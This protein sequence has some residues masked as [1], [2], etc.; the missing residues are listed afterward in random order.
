MLKFCTRIGFVITLLLAFGL[1]LFATGQTEDAAATE[2]GQ[3]LRVGLRQ[4]TTIDPALG[5]NDPEVMFNR[6]QY[7]YLV[8]ISA[9]GDLSPSLA[10]DWTISE[11]G[12][13]YTFN[14]RDDV[15]FEDGEQ[16]TAD[17][18]VF[19][20]NRLV[21]QG[22]SIVS[23]LGQRQTGETEDGSAIFEPTWTVEAADDFTAVFRLEEPNADF[24]FGVASRFSL[25]VQAG[26]EN[27]NTIAQG[28]DPYANFNGTGPF[29]LTEYEPDQRATFVANES[30]WMEGAPALDGLELVFF[31]N[32]QTQLDALRSGSLDFIIKVPEDL[33]DALNRVEGVTVAS[34]ATN[35]HPVIRLR[36]DE[37]SIGEDV[38]MRQAFKFAT[39]RELINQ[40]VLGGDGTVANN[41]PI[42]PTYGSLYNPQDNRG[43]DPE[44]A[45]ELIAEVFADGAGNG[46]IEEVDGQPRI[47]VPFYVGDTFEYPLVAEFVQQQWAE[48]GIDVE[49]NVVPEAVYYAEGDNNWLNTQLGMTAWGTRPTPQE[50]LSVAYTTGAPFNEARWSN[51][52]L[53]SLAEEASRTADIEERAELYDQISGIFFESGPI[54]IPYFRPV[55][56]GYVDTI[57]GLDMH[58]FPGRTDFRSVRF[59]N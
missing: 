27:V 11:D 1:P 36:T 4:L 6:V 54:L 49:L 56:G 3:V 22:S 52:E 58:S 34:K 8:E 37:G 43:F 17:D 33:V 40:D 24:V 5:A 12:L 59:Q 47:Q 23:L 2:E 29:I 39:D 31:D 20:F 10:T 51:D 25:I 45:L 21:E 46:F 55:V 50:Y 7:D 38:R 19:T 9:D 44:R 16:F 32:D 35:T 48:A 18:V 41:D 26:S 13:T 57:E 28:D 30:Y 53:D 14:L 15:Q 42:G